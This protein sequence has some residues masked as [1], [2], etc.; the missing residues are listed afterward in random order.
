MVIILYNFDN[1]TIILCM[2]KNSKKPEKEAATIS[3]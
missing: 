2:L 3:F 1:I